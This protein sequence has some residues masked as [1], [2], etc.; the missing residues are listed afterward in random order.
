[1]FCKGVSYLEFVNLVVVLGKIWMYCDLNLFGVM[2][3]KVEMKLIIMESVLGLINV[4]FCMYID[5]FG[6]LVLFKGI[7]FYCE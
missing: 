2:E 7:G 3:V 4:G 6:V 5:S 1:M